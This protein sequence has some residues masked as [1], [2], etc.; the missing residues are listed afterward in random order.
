MLNPNV[1]V[2]GYCASPIIPRPFLEVLVRVPPGV[3]A[4]DEVDELTW[5]DASGSA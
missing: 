4:A 1:R 5:F 2:D 3:F